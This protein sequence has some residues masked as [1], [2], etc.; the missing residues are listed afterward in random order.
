VGISEEDFAK[1][2]K[3]YHQTDA[4]GLDRIYMFPQDFIAQSTIALYGQD[5]TN[6][7]GYKNGVMPTGAYLA[8]ASGPDCVQYLAAMCPGTKYTRIVDGPWFY[9]TDMSFVKRFNSGKG[10][11]IEFRLDIFNI[12]DNVN[13]V[14]TT[15]TGSNPVSNWDVTAAATDLNAAQDPGGRIT[16][17]S[18]RFTW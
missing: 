17:Y 6:P 2:F 18:L 16:Q 5:V 13:F 10:T 4:N 8:P 14:A 12:F 11:R 7:T 3:F 15:R 9:R 1:S